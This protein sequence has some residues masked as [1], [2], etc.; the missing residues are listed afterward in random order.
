MIKKYS[1]INEK[2]PHRFVRDTLFYHGTDFPGKKLDTSF[3]GKGHDHPTSVFGIFFTSDKE[4]AKTYGSNIIQAYLNVKKPYHMLYGE[5]QSFNS[6]REAVLFKKKLQE[7]GFDS[8]YIEPLVYGGEGQI[9]VFNKSDI[10][11]FKKL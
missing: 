9:A 1:Q 2:K 7:Q 4:L 10:E 8:I 3:A 6:K 5:A 11:V